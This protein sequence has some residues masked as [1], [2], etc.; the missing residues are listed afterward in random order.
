MF[1]VA[2]GVSF[3]AIG[4]VAPSR[5]DSP[6]MSIQGWFHAATP[7]P[8]A[9]LATRAQLQAGGDGNGDGGGGG[10]FEGARPIEPLAPFDAAD[11]AALAPLV[12]AS[13]LDA[14]NWPRVAAAFKDDGSVHLR[15]FLTPVWAAA[16]SAAT[17]AADAADGVGRGAPPKHGVGARCGWRAEGPA[18]KQRFLRYGGG[19]GA[20]TF[21]A[22]TPPATI[23]DA[24]GTDPAARAGALLAHVGAHVLGAAPFARLLKGLTS[25]GVVARAA[26]P[27][28][29]RF[30]PGLDYTVAHA[31]V[32]TT[33][34]R[35]DAVL[36][37]VDEKGESGGG[38]D[39]SSSSQ[40]PTTDPWAAGDVGGYEAYLLADDAGDAAEYKPADAAGDDGGGVL[41]VAP[42]ANALSLV[43][44]DEGLLRFVKCVSMAAPGSRWDVGCVYVPEEGETSEEEEGG[45]EEE[46]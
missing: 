19:G 46:G 21:P 20:T 28:A 32:L 12:N 37:F 24:A 5:R 7:P 30:R 10:A 13:Y 39:A 44:R 3:H 43:L 29:R 36:T 9:E 4:E 26:A 8:G 15:N 17:A 22:D 38:E 11:A 40:Q 16:L 31:G 34:P 35:L 27:A 2:P 25:I 33:D 18:H 41:N 23:A 42:A 14:A 6:R 45:G 1:A